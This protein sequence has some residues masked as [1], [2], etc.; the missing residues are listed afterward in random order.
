MFVEH[1]STSGTKI[2]P[3]QTPDKSSIATFFDYC[4]YRSNRNSPYS[5]RRRITFHF[6]D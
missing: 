5:N 3:R 4:F 2:V 6:F 1:Q